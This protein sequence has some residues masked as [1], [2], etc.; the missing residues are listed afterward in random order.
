MDRP[1]RAEKLIALKRYPKVFVKISHTWSLSK[2]EY[3]FRDTYPQVK[4]LY[5]SLRPERLMWGTDWPVSKRHA[6]Y[7][8]T[9]SVVRDEMKFLNRDDKQLDLE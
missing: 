4:R 7:P 5:D 1:E 2:E 8:Q 9:L 6:S 3:P